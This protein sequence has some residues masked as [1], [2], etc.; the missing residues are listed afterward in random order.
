MYLVLGLPRD[1]VSG[2]ILGCAT[3]VFE[4]FGSIKTFLREKYARQLTAQDST[5]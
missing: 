1:K 3:E 2:W 5:R 4:D